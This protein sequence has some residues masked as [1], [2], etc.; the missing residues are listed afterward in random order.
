MKNNIIDLILK[1]TSTKDARLI[2]VE[3]ENFVYGKNGKRITVNLSSHY[4]ASDLLYDLI[5]D[6]E[7]NDEK[8][9]YS[10]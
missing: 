4:S 3:I 9:D 5:N 6:K 2:G 7:K 10:M 8:Y 1:S